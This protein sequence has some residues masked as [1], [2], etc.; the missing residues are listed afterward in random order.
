MIGDCCYSTCRAGTLS[1]RLEVGSSEQ[2][3]LLLMLTPGLLLLVFRIHDP[4]CCSG[5]RWLTGSLCKLACF[6]AGTLSVRLEAR[7]SEQQELG[8]MLLI[9]S[10]F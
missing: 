2:Q 3:E 5:K 8:M 10:C 9:G 7:S 6:R 1:V 4:A